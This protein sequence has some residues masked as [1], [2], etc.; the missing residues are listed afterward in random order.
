MPHYNPKKIQYANSGKPFEFDFNYTAPLP[1]SLFRWYKNGKVFTGDEGR[2]TIE[3]TGISFTR[4]LPADA[5]QYT[6]KASIQSA[7]VTAV[8]TLQGYCLQQSL[9]RL[10]TNFLL[11]LFFSKMVITFSL[12]AAHLPV[13]FLEVVDIILVNTVSFIL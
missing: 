8:S 7:L 13:S 12:Q 9:D 11:Q 4:V 1:P 3:H 5:G 10:H 6:V 2:V